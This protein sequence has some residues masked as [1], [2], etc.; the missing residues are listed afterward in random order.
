MTWTTAEHLAI[1]TALMSYGVPSHVRT[2]SSMESALSIPT[3][4]GLSSIPTPRAISTPINTLGMNAAPG[5]TCEPRLCEPSLPT[6][7]EKTNMTLMILG[8]IQSILQGKLSIQLLEE[9][10]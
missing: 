1:N 2:H 7:G 4:E 6:I 3:F 5:N 10:S 9:E 8:A